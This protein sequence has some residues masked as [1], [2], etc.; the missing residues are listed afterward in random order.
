VAGSES[1]AVMKQIPTTTAAV[2]MA[3]AWRQGSS[4]LPRLNRLRHATY[5]C[6]ARASC[7]A[8]FPARWKTKSAKWNS[9]GRRKFS[10]RRSETSSQRRAQVGAH[11]RPELTVILSLARVCSVLLQAGQL[12]NAPLSRFASTN[13][14]VILGPP[15]PSSNKGFALLSEF[16][17]GVPSTS[18][19]PVALTWRNND[20]SRHGI[21]FKDHALTKQ[22]Q[23]RPREHGP[24]R[25]EQHWF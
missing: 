17:G 18:R 6:Q 19:P 7:W 1:D 25:G 2:T 24:S 20:A 22:K 5:S 9:N 15:I 21:G 3:M 11:R 10:V 13:S 12:S 16:G 23:Q 14:C 4:F 8:A